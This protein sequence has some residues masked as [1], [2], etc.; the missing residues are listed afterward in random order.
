MRN[1]S[2]KLGCVACTSPKPGVDVNREKT[3]EE[4]PLFGF[5]PGSLFSRAGFRARV[6]HRNTDPRNR[7]LQIAAT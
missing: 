6:C 5:G 4:K 3:T 2:E 7:N 1:K